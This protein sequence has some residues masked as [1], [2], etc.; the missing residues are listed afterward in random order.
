MKG[1]VC[2]VWVV[3]L[4]RG[5]G[6]GRGFWVSAFP[7]CHLCPCP[8]RHRDLGRHL[9]R[10]G[11]DPDPFHI[12]DLCPYP[13]HN[14]SLYPAPYPVLATDRGTLSA[15]HLDRACRRLHHCCCAYPSSGSRRRSLWDGA[16]GTAIATATVAA[17]N[18]AWRCGVL[19]MDCFGR[20]AREDGRSKI[21]GRIT[22]G[23]IAS[24]DYIII[25][26]QF[27][28]NDIHETITGKMVTERTGQTLDTRMQP[29]LILA[30]M[31]GN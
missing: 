8:C 31:P 19:G 3:N 24:P 4:Y 5:R 13:S 17:G 2:R 10:A 9:C 23:R 21:G 30:A 29:S 22:V 12:P 27:V 25:P 16:A 1:V 11:L 14:P 28:D 18:L 26:G 6:R 7:C 15:I 20:R